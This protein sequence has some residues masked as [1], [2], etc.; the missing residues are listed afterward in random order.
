MYFVQDLPAQDR[1]RERLLSLGP[2]A[3]SA[4]E[5]LAI[6]LGSGT[7]EKSVL[8]LSQELLVRFGS[9][10]QLAQA[11]T[12]ELCSVKGIGEAK[13]VL[14]QAVFSLATK[15]SVKKEEARPHLLHPS[16]VYDL[17]KGE[18][19]LLNHEEFWVLLLDAKGKWIR[20]EVVSQ[21]TL[22]ESLVHPREF[23]HPAIRHK[24]ARVIAVH[25]HPSGDPTPSSQ[26]LSLTQA[27][28]AAGDLLGIPLSDHLIVGKGKYVSLRERGGWRKKK[29]E[30]PLSQKTRLCNNQS[31]PEG[32]SNNKLLTKSGKRFTK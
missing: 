5:L 22:T 14:L 31:F 18:M 11:S 21:G 27:L 13:A 20:K 30:N 25:N 9:L 15:L 23:F 19:E 32:H 3:L 29:E 12:E 26:D 16:S 17:V 28:I 1:P 10:S 8:E 24:A 2:S 6:L 4:A 7:K